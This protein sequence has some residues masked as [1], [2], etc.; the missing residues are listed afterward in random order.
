ML[1]ALSKIYGAAVVWNN[2]RF[3]SGSI[4]PVKCKA[5]VISIGNISAGGS[6]K[7]PF[8]IMLTKEIIRMGYRPAIVGK[9]Y[10]RKSRG[11]KIVS[12]GIEIFTN[13]VEAG[14]EMFMLA[15]RL[16]VPVI[17]HDTKAEAALVA[18]NRF[19]PDVI[20]IDDGFQHRGLYRDL[21][22]VLLDAA[23]LERPYLLP[24]GRLREPLSS[25][26]RADIISIPE[27]G[28]KLTDEFINN[29]L[30]IASSVQPAGIFD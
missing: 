11:L 4:I 6:G 14:D 30:I 7:T 25:L 27:D 16:R 8:T 15:E 28:V 1:S 9:G 2:K 12:D 21:D 23:S 18:D 10:K 13:P 29:K 19:K 26:N 24:K 20:I 5:P 22:I 17:V 3:D